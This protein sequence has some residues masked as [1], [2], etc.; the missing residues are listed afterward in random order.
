MKQHFFAG[1]RRALHQVDL[2]VA[3]DIVIQRR[4]ELTQKQFEECR[5]II[6]EREREHIRQALGR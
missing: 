6:R 2:D 4:P 3:R 1:I 5:K